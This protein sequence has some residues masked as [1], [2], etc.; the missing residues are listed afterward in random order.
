MESQARADVSNG[1]GSVPLRV[2]L[3]IASISWS[4]LFLLGTYTELVGGT[5]E[6]LF[7]DLILLAAPFLIARW[8]LERNEG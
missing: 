8:F 1:R 7:V 4:L 2:A 6:I 5:L 3:V